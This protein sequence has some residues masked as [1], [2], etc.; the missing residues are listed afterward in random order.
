MP[1][2]A[3]ATKQSVCNEPEYTSAN[4]ASIRVAIIDDHPMLC[5]GVADSFSSEPGFE[6]VGIG[7]TADS[8][9]E[10]AHTLSPDLMV[11][12]INIP[13]NGLRAVERIVHR[14]PHIRIMMLT[15]YDDAA[16][17]LESLRSGAAGYVLKGVSASELIAAARSIMCGESYVPP[18]L[19]TELIG[20]SRQTSTPVS[21]NDDEQPV[22]LS[23]R[24]TQILSG[25]SR[26]LS[27]NE[28]AAEIGVAEKTVKNHITSLLRKLHVRNR[29][30]AALLQSSRSLPQN[31]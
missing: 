12:D 9:Y 24:E 5:A 27:N 28:I 31:G 22:I 13:G 18:G 1:A 23:K 20:I 16:T 30:E 29:V 8:A 26:G 6:V 3:M 15:A 25:I 10:I 19:A 7:S 21:N 11:V 2:S 17:V 4:D 14:M